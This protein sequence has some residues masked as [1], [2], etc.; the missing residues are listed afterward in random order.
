MAVA[1]RRAVADDAA[2]LHD[3]AAATFGLACPPGTRPE[4]IAA[5]IS[6]N[7]S[8]ESFAGHLAD[9]SR[10]LFIAMVDGE[11]A[12]YTMLITEEPHDPDVAAAITAHP[13]AEL[14]KVYVLESHHG[15]GVAASLVQTTVEAARERGSA[16]VWLGVNQENAKANR[17]YDKQGFALA[18][19]KKFLVGERWEDD[20]V[21]ELVFSE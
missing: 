12:G 10:D 21:R 4:A 3:L 11:L 7:L 8:V 20:F 6:T 19:T 13:T 16:G 14:S 15:S 18:G 5:F 1:I 2:L 17:F 9:A